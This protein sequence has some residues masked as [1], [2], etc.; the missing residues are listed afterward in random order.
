MQRVG[1][2]GL[3]ELRLSWL[4]LGRTKQPSPGSRVSWGLCVSESHSHVQRPPFMGDGCVPQGF[5]STYCVPL[6][7][8]HPFYTQGTQAPRGRATCLRSHGQGENPD[9]LGPKPPHHPLPAE[10]LAMA[11][12]PRCG[13]PTFLLLFLF[14]IASPKVHFETNRF[15]GCLEMQL[16]FS[17]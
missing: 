1:T 4:R 6:A 16:G 8:R 13:L 5:L 2:E 3:E 15:P 11:L 9:N 14:G 7:F 10:A 12:T 17:F